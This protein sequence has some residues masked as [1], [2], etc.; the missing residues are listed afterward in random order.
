MYGYTYFHNSIHNVQ[1][2]SRMVHSLPTDL[3]QHLHLPFPPLTNPLDHQ[4]QLLN[5]RCDYV[6]NP[7]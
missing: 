1:E 2:V 4:F 5:S 3:D 6:F 7:L